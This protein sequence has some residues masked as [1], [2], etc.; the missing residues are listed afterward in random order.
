MAINRFTYVPRWAG[1]NNSIVLDGTTEYLDLP[2]AAPLGIANAWSISMWMKPVSNSSGS[3]RLLMAKT[4]GT[5]DNQI[6]L[7]YSGEITGLV[8]AIVSSSGST[9]NGSPQSGTQ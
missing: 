6:L 9:I 3:W 2:A 8:G 5:F 1:E 7:S 4:A